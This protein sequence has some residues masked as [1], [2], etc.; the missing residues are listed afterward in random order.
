[1][2]SITNIGPKDWNGIWDDL[3]FY[4]YQTH[5]PLENDT[6]TIGMQD[7]SHILTTQEGKGLK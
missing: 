6:N 5:V 3:Y 2:F 7:V 4:E 1:M